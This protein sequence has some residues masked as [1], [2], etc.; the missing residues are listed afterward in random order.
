MAVNPLIFALDYPSLD[1][2][3]AGAERVRGRVGMVKVG[4]ELYLRYGREALALGQAA[5]ADVF[6]DLKLHDIPATVGRA[7]ANLLRASGETR[8]RL[9]TVHCSGGAAMLEQA[10]QATAGSPLKIVGVTV[11][12]SLDDGDLSAMSIHATAAEQAERLATLAWQSGVRH[13]VCSPAEVA[14]IR[15]ALGSE[16]TLITPGVR[17]AGSAAGDQK[18]VTT[19]REAIERGADMLVV[20]RPIRDA[21][22]PAEAAA[23]IVASLGATT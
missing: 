20:G 5:D 1:E 9:L 10:V 4:L 3:R 6:V 12:T 11:L 8:A 15:G 7:A 13:F 23:A 18:R 14:S 17:P 22:D 16:A 19:P 2:A 21:D